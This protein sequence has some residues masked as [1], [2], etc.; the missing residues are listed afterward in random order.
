MRCTHLNILK[1]TDLYLKEVH[2][3]SCILNKMAK[4]FKI[5]I[6][7]PFQISPSSAIL[8]PFCFLIA[9]VFVHS[10]FN[11]MECEALINYVIPQ[12]KRQLLYFVFTC[13]SCFPTSTVSDFFP[14]P[15]HSFPAPCPIQLSDI[16]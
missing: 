1:Y 4:V 5:A 8:V 9:R 13:T 2:H 16:S 7:N 11:G 6:C 14:R 12:M 10:D 15:L 3:H